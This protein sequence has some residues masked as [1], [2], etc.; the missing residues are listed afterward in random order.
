[1][2][3][4]LLILSVLF[5][6]VQISC[7][8]NNI[9]Q[10]FL[11]WYDQPASDWNEALPIGN[12]LM[13]AMIFGGITNEHLQLNENTL[14]S[15]E[16]SQ[17]YK[18]VNITGDF[19]KVIN[20]L[21][22]QKNAEADEYVRKNWLGR[23]H[24]NYQPLGDL[25]IKAN[26][27]GKVTNYRRELD[28]ANSISRVSY[29]V[30]GVQYTREMF[31]SHPDSIIVVKF[32][33]SK[34]I[35]D[36]VASLASVH[37]TAKSYVENNV[38]LIHGQAPGYSSR[39]TLEQIEQRGET[40]RHPE[41]FDAAGKRIFEKQNLYGD[42][43]GGLGMFFEAQIKANLK[44]GELTTDSTTIHIRN[45]SDV[46]FLISAATSFNGFDKSP[47]KEG[48]NPNKIAGRILERATSKSYDDLKNIHESDYQNLYNRFVLDLVSN[49]SHDTIPTDRRIVSFAQNNDPDLVELLF[50]YGRYLMI[51]G[52]REGG[53]PLNL[54][55]IWNDLVIPP[56][57]SG[58][59]ININT[60]MNYWPTEVTNLAECHQPLF[61]MIKE[62]A[63]TGRE[64]AKHMYNRRGWVAHHNVSIWRETFPNDGSPV[65]SFWNM[66]AGWLLSHM[67]EHYLFSGDIEFLRNEAYPLM[68]EAAMFYSDWLIEN[69]DGFLVTAVNNSPENTFFNEKGERSQISSGPTMDMAIV[70][71]LFTRT[72]ESAKI[73]QTD[74]ELV[75][76]LSTK[77]GQLI[78]Y[79]IGSKGQ[80]QEW[81]ID[82]SEP[83]PKHRHISHLYPLHPGNQID[84]DSSPELMKAAKQTL[85]LRGDEATGWSMGWKIN[86]WARLLDG[87]H[88]YTIIQ[89]LFKPVGFG[90][91]KTSGGGLFKNL[92]D[93]CPPFQIDGN[94]G[95]TAG[96][97]EML[98]QSH[99]GYIHLL[100]ALP[101]AWPSGEA[102]G[103]VA[104]GGFV[105][106]MSW[107]NNKLQN[108]SIYSRLG[109]NCRIKVPQE[110]KCREADLSEP[111]TENSNPLMRKPA[112][113]PFT[114]ESGT[115]LVEMEIASG[116]LYEWE[117]VAGNTYNFEL[118]NKN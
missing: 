75:T 26:H 42:E 13:G 51:S 86:M 112:P 4:K 83:E 35:L 92:F 16:P 40:K 3:K 96:V 111:S 80:L 2:K 20:L 59:T 49:I 116:K 95:F 1:M 108:L 60:E 89:N 24:A 25:F 28:I 98:V 38:L 106:D 23:L 48:L 54:Q 57:N 21:R 91:K 47:S 117:T 17:S 9:N 56:W 110:M 118:K 61:R 71:E 94:F 115:K 30:D 87:N 32:T 85:L 105:I 19:N 67:W 107:A 33:A 22:D 14:Y 69:N 109:G 103:L 5:V 58:Y 77:L 43:I 84:F 15:G 104:R 10:D 99:N 62:M 79:K 93:A 6:F 41:L 45:S 101:S 52:S 100:P 29:Q 70:R 18:K 55:G 114:N 36:L 53:Q 11:L 8:K 76:E 31:A 113:A 73:L 34:P 72:I 82:F 12:G 88:A 66:S 50:N 7:K 27:S 74:A 102:K 78:P 81:Q 46:V 65:A 97:A 68:R 44:D 90:E 37:P 64:T 63:V 39:R